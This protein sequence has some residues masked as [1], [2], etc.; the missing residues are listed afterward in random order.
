[1]NGRKSKLIRREAF[2][3]HPRGFPD[4]YF[5]NKTT[6]VNPARQAKKQARKDIEARQRR[7]RGS[8]SGA[9]GNT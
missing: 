2:T 3:R 9:G 5:V 6:L 8:H 7:S 4:P 1:M